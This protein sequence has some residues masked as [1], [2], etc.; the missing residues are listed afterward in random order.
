MDPDLRKPGSH[1][2]QLNKSP[3]QQ[4][5]KIYQQ[6][7]DQGD[8]LISPHRRKPPSYMGQIG[9]HLGN[10]AEA[11]FHVEQEGP[12]SD[13]H[14]TGQG[15]RDCY[16]PRQRETTGNCNQHTNDLSQ[17]AEEAQAHMAEVDRFL[18]LQP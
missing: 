8:K 4:Q 6:T 13:P 9:W 16:G 2:V 12:E 10:L 15:Y 1:F 7:P 11:I 3:P 17:T 5:E 18:R 14:W